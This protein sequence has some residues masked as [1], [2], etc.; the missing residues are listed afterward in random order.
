MRAAPAA[1][2]RRWRALA[3]LVLVVGAAHLWLANRVAE[4][5]IGFAAEPALPPRI[6]V[7]FVKQLQAAEPPAPPARSRPVPRRAPPRLPAVS[8]QPALAAASAPPSAVDAAASAPEPA[9]SASAAEYPQPVAQAEPLAPA[10]PDLPPPPPPTASAPAAPPAE[11]EAS[12]TLSAQAAASAAA[13]DPTGFD[14][15]PSTRLRYRLSGHYRGPMEGTAQV[16]WLRS[17]SHYQ[18]RMGTAIGPVVR[19]SIVSDGVLTARGLTPR[20]FSGEQKVLFSDPRRWHI[21]F[22]DQRV[23]LSDGRE[24]DTVAGVQ[25]EASQFVQLTWLFRTQALRLAVGQAIELPLVIS[26]RLE[27]WTYEVVGEETLYFPFGQM[28][29]FHVKPRRDATG[30]DMT[31]EMWFA[32]TLQYLPVRILIRQGSESWANLTLEQLPEQGDAGARMNDER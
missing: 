20:R 21:A 7:A 25:D 19:R 15:P 29:T 30:G 27:R 28:P 3:A 4:A 6:E 12:A 8:A 5:R 26:R 2:R 17:G 1:A 32:P 24:V 23:R 18:V 31:A 9:A 16:E 22:D 14:W 10:L 11:P 13:G